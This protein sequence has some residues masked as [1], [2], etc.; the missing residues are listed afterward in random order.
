MKTDLLVNKK[1]ITVST[2]AEQCSFTRVHFVLLY[3]KT[4]LTKEVFHD[5]HKQK[6]VSNK[7]NKILF[8]FVK[9]R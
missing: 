8:N 3:I 7:L 5:I 9:N 2:E 1:K 4:R 6:D